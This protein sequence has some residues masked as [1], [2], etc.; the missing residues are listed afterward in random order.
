VYNNPPV[1]EQYQ[2]FF[3]AITQTCGDIDYS[4]WR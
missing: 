3:S 4:V 2:P 1:N